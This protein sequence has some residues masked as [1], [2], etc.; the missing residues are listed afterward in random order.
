MLAQ[1]SLLAMMTVAA[2]VAPIVP[3]QQPP[4]GVATFRTSSNLVIVNL[5]AKDKS[6]KPI[7]NLKKEDF[8]VFEDEKPQTL[9]VF[10]L[11]KLDGEK[12]PDLPEGPG[13][14]KERVERPKPAAPAPGPA[15]TIRFQ[16]KRLIGLLFDF[17]SMAPAEQ[18]RAQDAAIK[19][20]RTQM[21]AADLV[22]IMTFGTQFKVVEEFTADRE[23]LIETIKKFRIGESSELAVDGSSPDANDDSDDGS[24]FVAD[25][26]EFNIFNTDRKLTALETAAKKL[27][28]FPEKK[29]LVYF[30]S[31]VSK[32]G[33]E[34]QAQLRA[35]I[36][37]AVRANVAFYPVDARGLV[38]M[39]PAGDASTASARGTGVFTGRTQTNARDK[40]HDQQETLYSLAADTGG[41][42]LLDSNDLAIGITQAQK[43]VDSY[44]ILGYYST[45]PATDGRFRK[46]R[47]RLVANPLQAKLD[48]RAG[49]Y[50]NKEWKNFNSSDKERQLEEALQLGDPVNELALALEV[51]YFRMA[52]GSYFVPIAV[53]IPGSAVGLSKKG[54][55]QAADLDFIGQI[56]D[57]KGR[58]VSGVRDNITVKLSEV[59][60]QQLGHRPLQYDTGLTL[61]PG[62]Y[63]LK[64][65]AREN[66]SGK[67]GTFETKF[68]IPDVN[69]DGPKLRMSSVVWSGQRDPVAAAVGTAGGG[70]KKLLTR[71]PLVQDGQKLVPSIT[72][73]FRKNQNLY[74][75]FEVY[76]PTTDS[77]RRAPS[78]AA[79]LALYSGAKKAFE[80]S[81]VRLAQLASNRNGTI[82]FQLQVPLANLAPGRYTSQ[83][84]VIDE[85]GRKFGFARTP[86]ILLP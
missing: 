73:V 24:L 41:K 14:L 43:D 7:T 36:N 67:M 82:P 77:N 6:G 42:A 85:F 56:R 8:T 45:N 15:G 19:F 16:D 76:D 80:S 57:E 11:Q 72:R 65:L 3:A 49:Y 12:L 64:F 31:G 50:A 68:V 44:Y 35:T 75:Y 47:I 46:I 58:L 74:V 54:A 83:L 84:T 23:A 21:T 51:D 71:H 26:T 61:S 59:D 4:S 9:S 40:F 2:L 25:E 18:T 30:S 79:E 69:A 53:K 70:E 32:T 55:R 29:A 34:N 60:A 52:K 86:L 10:E 78:V 20:L 27:A 62:T 39:A 48:Y 66:H 1:R 81:P 28:M 33:V 13:T 63:D 38:A 17:S 37:A 5:T 22:S